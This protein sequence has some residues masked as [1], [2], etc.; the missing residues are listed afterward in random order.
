MQVT[1]KALMHQEKLFGLNEFK[2]CHYDGLADAS[3]SKAANDTCVPLLAL[4][5]GSKSGK[6]Q[7][8]LCLKGYSLSLA[9]IVK[10][11]YRYLSVYF[12]CLFLLRL[13]NVGAE[14]DF[15]WP[16][17]QKIESFAIL[18][19]MLLFCCAGLY[20]GGVF[21]TLTTQMPLARRALQ[22]FSLACFALLGWCIATGNELGAAL[23]VFVFMSL[24]MACM[25]LL[26]VS[27]ALH[28]GASER[29]FLAAAL[30]GMVGAGFSSMVLMNF[31]AFT[32]FTY[33]TLELIALAEVTLLA[34]ALGYQSRQQTRACLLAEHMACRDPLTDLYNRR[35]FLEMAR[36]IW[37][38]A[39]RQ[40]R[41]MA[42]I[43]LDIDH[44]KQV[45]DQFGHEVGDNVLVQTA[46]MLAEVCRSGDL[47]SRWG[48]EEFL[49][50][51][52]ETD[53][54]QARVFAERIRKALVALGL[55]V[56][57][58]SLFL[59]A[60]LGVAERGQKSSLEE[61]IKA[62]DMQLY[63]AKRGGRNRC[64]SESPPQVL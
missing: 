56:E 18:A 30:C 2:H 53:L 63:E 4:A 12:V 59:T 47:L 8:A 20:V 58:A 50:L 43:M 41:P 21:L 27:R 55:P 57:S 6:S 16:L 9:H 13:L 35:A 10:Y 34:F 26:G 31:L 37:S 39:Q 40:H 38:I 1:L 52:S 25:V 51:L 60:S 42:M 49:L 54:E 7:L 3:F 64:S 22:V 23:L 15:L 44:F 29:F 32:P 17:Q 62:A 24:F 19:L 28:G 11:P 61:L 48:G 45:N 14:V 36:P 33:H 46:N 5:S